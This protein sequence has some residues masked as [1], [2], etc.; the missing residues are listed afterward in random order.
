MSAPH[1]YEYAVIRV[2]PR[3]ER[4]EFIN[5]G[6][7]VFCKHQKYLRIQ[8][9][10][11]DEKIRLLATEFDLSQLKINVDAFLKICSGNKDGGPIAAFDMAERFRWLTAV[12]SSSLQTSRPHSGLSVDLDGTFERL[13]AE[14]VL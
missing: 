6:L 14:L 8:V 5:I 9:E 2:V 7:M 3:V 4:E 11:P 10:I 13:Y 1:L 12:K